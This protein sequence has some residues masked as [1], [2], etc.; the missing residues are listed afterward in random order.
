MLSLMRTASDTTTGRAAEGEDEFNTQ[1]ELAIFYSNRSLVRLSMS[2]LHES[3]EDANCAVQHD[4]Q[5]IKGHWRHGQACVALG[6]YKEGLVSF[7]KALELEPKNKALMR[8]VNVTKEKIVELEEKMLGLE[9]NALEEK[10]AANPAEDAEM[11]DSVSNNDMST[12]TT[13]MED[14]SDDNNNNIKKTATGTTKPS[15]KK[16]HTTNNTVETSAN[17]T[18]TN[19]F[20]KSDHVRGY[21]IRSD[22]TKTSFFDREISEDAKKLI[23]DIAPKKLD[24]GGASS[25]SL[26]SSSSTENN[27]A[28]SEGTSAWNTAGKCVYI[29][30]S[31]G[32]RKRK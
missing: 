26:L 15:S 16:K 4:P 20:T 5:Y 10:E 8:E 32:F 6:N 28:A 18:T 17:T 31:V 29:F 2:K 30:S 21:K 11:E 1:L 27:N 13:G 19:L 14:T 22:G 24:V 25:S 7:E 23:G 9:K 12:M 3:A